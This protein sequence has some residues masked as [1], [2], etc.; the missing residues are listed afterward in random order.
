MILYPEAGIIQKFIAKEGDTVTQGTKV[1]VISKSSP[2]DTCC[3]IR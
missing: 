3:L 1:A 2:G